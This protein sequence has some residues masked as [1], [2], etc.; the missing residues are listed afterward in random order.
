[1]FT[2]QNNPSHL[3]N[4]RR[5]VQ[6]NAGNKKEVK[7]MTKLGTL[8]LLLR[9]ECTQGGGYMNVVVVNAVQHT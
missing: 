4:Q 7:Q 3:S 5:T 2:A 8:I 9:D 1:M 6:N